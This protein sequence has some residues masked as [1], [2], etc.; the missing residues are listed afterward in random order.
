LVVEDR[1]MQ[2][3]DLSIAIRVREVELAGVI[4]R[5]ADTEG[6]VAGRLGAGDETCDRLGD[7]RVREGL[8]DLDEAGH[9]NRLVILGGPSPVVVS[10]P[11][12]TVPAAADQD[13]SHQAGS[14]EQSLNA[15]FDPAIVVD[16]IGI[17]VSPRH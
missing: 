6:T 10:V 11:M 14:G 2:L 4:G 15:L 13:S 16:H 17:V 7:G 9:T 5:R 1:H 3:D 8:G 12:V